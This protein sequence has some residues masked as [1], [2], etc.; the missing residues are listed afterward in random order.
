MLDD[1]TPSY[2]TAS[3]ALNTC[4]AELGHALQKLS[5]SGDAA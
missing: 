2:A 1:V 3:A 5:E 4:R